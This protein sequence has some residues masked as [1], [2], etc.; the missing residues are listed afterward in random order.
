ME[1]SIAGMGQD[2][3]PLIELGTAKLHRFA[4]PA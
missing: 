3:D 2:D 1:L 4:S